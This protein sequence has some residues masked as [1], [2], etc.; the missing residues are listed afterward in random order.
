MKDHRADLSLLLSGVPST[1]KST[2]GRW[3]EQEQGYLH[4]D[5]ENGG[6]NRVGLGQSWEAIAKLP[7]PSIEAF[8]TELRSLGKPVALDWGFRR[9]GFH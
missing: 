6:L 1:G 3:L 2:F 5:L 4:I 7:P 9:N 8:L